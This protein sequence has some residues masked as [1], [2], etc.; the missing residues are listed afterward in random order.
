MTMPTIQAQLSL[1]HWLPFRRRLTSGD[2]RWLSPQGAI[3]VSS[4]GLPLGSR[5]QVSLHGEGHRLRR[6]PAVIVRTE[7]SQRGTRYSLKFNTD[8]TQSDKH[9]GMMELVTYLARN[10]HARDL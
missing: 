4:A 8:V 6:I 5:I 1:G 2:V 3:V 7:P 9:R 10:F